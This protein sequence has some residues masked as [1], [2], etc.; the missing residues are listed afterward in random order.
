MKTWRNIF[1]IIVAI[2]SQGSWAQTPNAP[3][4]P[5]AAAAQ[6]ATGTTFV[7]QAAEINLTE[8]EL[9]KI[10]MT[11][12]TTPVFIKFS[13]QM[14]REL[15]AA[16]R[17]LEAIADKNSVGFPTTRDREH[18]AMIKRLRMEGGLDFDA[19]YAKDIAMTEDRAVALYQAEMADSNPELSSYAKSMLPALEQYEKVA[20]S[21]TTSSAQG[22]G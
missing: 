15:T 2:A 4:A 18:A 20:Q 1:W 5:A 17:S 9:S 7:Q 6:P 10:A 22:A 11:N 3:S 13:K 14:V 12:S 8:L 21:L 19:D 16:N